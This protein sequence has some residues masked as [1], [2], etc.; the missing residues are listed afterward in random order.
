MTRR[1]F[2]FWTLL[3][4][5]VSS[6]AL[7]DQPTADSSAGDSSAG[8]QQQQRFEKLQQTLQRVKFVGH[9]T[10]LGKEDGPLRKEEYTIL[11]AKKLEQ[12]DYW[13]LKARVKYGN[14]DVTLPMPLEI[15]WAGD[16]P[17][18]T[19]TKTE[20][21]GLGTFSA[22][23]VIDNNKYAGTWTH[24]KAS[25]HLFGIIEKMEDE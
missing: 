24:G 19:L 8:D 14:K 18:I 1:L 13:L 15:K 6:T 9:F 5:I 21:G 11:S 4:W 10:V 23:V 2:L 20:I 16:T 25:G 22:R 17:I 12:G 7:A 3:A